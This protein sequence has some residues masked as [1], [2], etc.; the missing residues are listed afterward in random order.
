MSGVVRVMDLGVLLL[1]F[2]ELLCLC[3]AVA[4]LV[5]WV[6]GYSAVVG[7]CPR[8]RHLRYHTACGRAESENV[9]RDS[10]ALITG[11]AI[12]DPPI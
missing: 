5:S 11:R 4:R 3:R 10:E 2:L 1:A 12:S 6:S 7:G 9:T 8:V